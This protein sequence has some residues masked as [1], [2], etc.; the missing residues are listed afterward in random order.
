MRQLFLLTHVSI[1]AIGYKSG[2]YIYT[3]TSGDQFVTRKLIIN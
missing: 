2:V 1:D 3:T